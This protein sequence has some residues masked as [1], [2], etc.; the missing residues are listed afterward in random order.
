LKEDKSK[1][2]DTT[3]TVKS[4]VIAPPENAGDRLEEEM[5]QGLSEG[6]SEGGEATTPN[7]ETKA[8]GRH[9][10][11]EEGTGRYDDAAVWDQDVDNKDICTCGTSARDFDAEVQEMGSV[12]HGGFDREANLRQMDS[13]ESG[14]RGCKRSPMCSD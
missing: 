8:T 12:M 5:V 7:Q 1:G 13:P 10:G 14:D 4:K 6:G 11:H 3:E 2:E 9:Q